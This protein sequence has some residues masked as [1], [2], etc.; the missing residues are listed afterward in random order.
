ME[1]ATKPQSD[2]EMILMATAEMKSLRHSVDR[3]TETFERFEEVKI[4]GIE[5]RLEKLESWKS[6]LSGGWKLFMLFW[7]IITAAIVTLVKSY[8]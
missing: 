2:R 6:Q 3:L 4:V 1:D 7:A 8:F 5:S